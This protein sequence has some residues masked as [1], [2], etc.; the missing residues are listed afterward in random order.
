MTEAWALSRV[1]IAWARVSGLF[2]L[3]AP[4]SCFRNLG[5]GFD[6]VEDLVLENHPDQ[7]LPLLGFAVLGAELCEVLAGLFGQLFEPFLDL[8]V[9]DLDVFFLG[10]LGHEQA[11]AHFH[12][13]VGLDPRTELR[14][15][16]RGLALPARELD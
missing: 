16:G 3:G 1:S 10:D 12:L 13:A 14:R 5:L 4:R 2:M 11:R 6:D 15:D 9:A 8:R 7:G